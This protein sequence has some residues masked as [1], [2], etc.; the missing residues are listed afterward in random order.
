MGI[1]GLDEMLNGGI[2]KGR[3][4]LLLG[5]PGAGKTVLATQFLITGCNAG[6]SGIYVS[7]DESKDHYYSEMESFGW[8]LAKYEEERLFAFVDASP[9][10]H[11]PG[12]VKLGKIAIGRRDFSMISLIE[13]VE[14]SVKEIDA[15]RIIVDSLSFITFQYPD[16]IEMRTA[17]LD[18][19]EALVKT[20]A[21]CLI[22]AELRSTGIDRSV[23]IE[24]YLAHGV[25]ILRSL[26]LKKSLVR[27][28]QMEKM[29]ETHID[30][31]MRPYKITEKG[32]EVFSKE[33][34]F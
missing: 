6:E 9:I 20:G 4:V 23:Q 7:L 29:R 26:Q 3:V 24:E 16:P 10:R 1:L 13:A 34:V 5:D 19:I 18:L 12:E 32:I 14:T 21:T 2:P 33:S 8:S 28:I 15:K 31:Q 22:T 25:I 30:T 17:L 11:L 27:T